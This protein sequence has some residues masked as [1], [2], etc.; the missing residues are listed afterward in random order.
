M[1]EAG[2]SAPLC[3]FPFASMR[4]TPPDWLKNTVVGLVSGVFIIMFYFMLLMMVIGFL[5]LGYELLFS[6]DSDP[7][8]AP[9]GITTFRNESEDWN[10]TA[11][12]E[13]CQERRDQL[14]EICNIDAINDLTILTLRECEWL[15]SGEGGPLLQSI[16]DSP[17][18]ALELGAWPSTSFLES[19]ESIPFFDRLE[20]KCLNAK[21]G[22][23]TLAELSL[24]ID[25]F[26]LFFGPISRM[27]DS[28]SH[29]IDPAI[30]D[31]N[32]TPRP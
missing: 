29:E 8:N 16:C 6:E 24:C 13:R 17:Y 11:E 27:F 22:E 32:I 28:V 14:N 7:T 12:K 9:A 1:G 23:I 21:V 2:Q 26:P 18:L 20:E 10:Q 3:F 30:T 19:P 15:R 31:F 4:Y 5:Y 25:R